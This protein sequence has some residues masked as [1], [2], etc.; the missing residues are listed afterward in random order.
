MFFLIDE[1]GMLLPQYW[2]GPIIK[3]AENSKTTAV[4]G[5]NLLPSVFAGGVKDLELAVSVEAG[6]KAFP[7]RPER[8]GRITSY[9]RTLSRISIFALKTARVTNV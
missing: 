2:S 9:F 4:E 3:V 7:I 8:L 6:D 5:A 1:V